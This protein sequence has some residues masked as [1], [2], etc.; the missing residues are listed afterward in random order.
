MDNVDNYTLEDIEQFLI[1]YKENQRL[2][3]KDWMVRV[4]IFGTKM[5]EKAVLEKNKVDYFI[6]AYNNALNSTKKE[7][8]ELVKKMTPILDDFYGS[9]KENSNG[10]NKKKK[11]V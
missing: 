7:Q 4:P 9:K 6:K 2:E 3:P 5:Y 1:D 8:M 10:S 11:I